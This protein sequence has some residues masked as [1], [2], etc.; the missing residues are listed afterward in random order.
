MDAFIISLL[1]QH[2]ERCT[3]FCCSQQGLCQYGLVT[4]KNQGLSHTE[5]IMQI[6]VMLKTGRTFCR[7]SCKNCDLRKIA[8]LTESVGEQNKT[9]R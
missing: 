8:K 4:L 6:C 5:N 2:K 7:N 1:V 3:D 9:K